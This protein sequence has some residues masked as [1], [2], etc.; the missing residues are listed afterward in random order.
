MCSPNDVGNFTDFILKNKPVPLI[1]MFEHLVCHFP[2]HRAVGAAVEQD[3]VISLNVI[4]YNGVSCAHIR[5]NLYVFCIH[6]R[7]FE[8]FDQK[9]PVLS[10]R[11]RM[12]Y[13]SPGSAHCNGLIQPLAAAVQMKAVR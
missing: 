5:Q 10:D 2:C 6:S 8:K 11:S 1:K 7:A 3:A 9:A 12:V 13:L 4:L